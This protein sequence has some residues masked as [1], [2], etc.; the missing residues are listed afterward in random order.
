[1]PAECIAWQHVGGDGHGLSGMHV[2][3]LT[4]LE[5]GI[6]PQTAC[7][8]HRDKLSADGGIRAGAG[9]AI[10]DDARDWRAQLGVAQIEPRNRALAFASASAAC[11]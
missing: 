11:V 9:A 8:H 2:R 6:D 5:V 10:A 7:R 4:L 3:Q 1:M